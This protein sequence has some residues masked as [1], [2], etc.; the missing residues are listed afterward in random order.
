[1]MGR[2]GR[3]GWLKR[4]EKGDHL[5]VQRALEQMGIASLASSSIGELSG[6]QQQRVFLA[7]AL[8]QEPHILLMDE[9]F[10]G[11]DAATQETTL[12]LLDE[13][14]TRQVTVMV[15]THDLNMAARRFESVLLLNKRVVAYGPPADV[16]HADHI[17]QA[18]S[19]QALVVDGV[20]VVDECCPP[21]EH[22]HTEP[23]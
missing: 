1:M 20:I 7:R 3:L 23:Q 2:F 22:A 14:K 8:A 5:A 11:V 10:T 12:A 6:G 9:P 16:F 17:R 13:M 21:D 19:G 15:S 18:F 4:P